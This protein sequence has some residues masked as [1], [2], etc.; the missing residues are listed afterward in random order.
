MSEDRQKRNTIILGGLIGAIV[1]VVAAVMLVRQVEEDDNQHSLT[2]GKG[3]Q[4]GMLVLG[5]LRQIT[6]I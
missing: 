6:Q 4:I 3:V 2:V 5:L 1:G